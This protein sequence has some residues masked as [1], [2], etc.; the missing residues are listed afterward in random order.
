M[1]HVTYRL[2]AKNRDQLRN[3]TLGNRVRATFTFTFLIHTA[4]PDMTTVLSMSRRF[5]GVNWIPDNSRLSPTENLK[6]K[7]VYSNCPIHTRHDTDRTVLSCLAGGVNWALGVWLSLA[8]RLFLK[9]AVTFCCPIYLLL[10]PDRGAEYCGEHVCVCICL[11][12]YV[13][14]CPR[15]YLRNYTSDIHQLFCA[16]CLWPWLGL[17]LAA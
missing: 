14:V 4:T 12:V 9:R 2:T 10:R 15:S 7:H 6:S 17:L 8:R 13:F 5:G 3:P 1:T 11:C 16:C